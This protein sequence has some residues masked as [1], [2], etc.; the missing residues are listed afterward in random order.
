[1][2]GSQKARVSE[3][4]SLASRV[5]EAG[6]LGLAIVVKPSR[7]SFDNAAVPPHGGTIHVQGFK[8]LP[9]R[10]QLQETLFHGR[11]VSRNE[12]ARALA[13]LFRMISQT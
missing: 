9:E 10:L 5:G 3:L 12:L 8:L 4:K 2:Q 6:D 11:P 13:R 7:Q 1:M